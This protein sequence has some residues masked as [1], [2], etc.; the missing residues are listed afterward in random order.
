MEI[1]RNVVVII[2]VANFVYSL[3]QTLV[4]RGPRSIF[5]RSERSA[6]T[7]NLIIPGM[8]HPPITVFDPFIREMKGDVMLINFDG[9]RWDT[10]RFKAAIEEIVSK[11]GYSK[12]NIFTISIG[13]KLIRG[14]IGKRALPFAGSWQYANQEKVR[15]YAINPC[16]SAELV[17]ARLKKPLKIAL[18][19]IGVVVYALGPLSDLKV[20]TIDSVKH[21]L[22]ELLTQGWA[23]VYEYSAHGMGS[24]TRAIL[25]TEDEFIDNAMAEAALRDTSYLYVS[26]SH[27]NFVAYRDEFLDALRK[28]GAFD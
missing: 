7:L 6:T 3:L 4:D 1:I 12:V 18:P 26:A 5:L 15:I 13:D 2:V 9:M 10:N 14:S 20:I 17:Q 25:S 24:E 19:I 21:S 27:A 23:T 22:M 8:C 28:L 16:S 11:P